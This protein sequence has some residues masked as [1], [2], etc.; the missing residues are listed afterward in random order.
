MKYHGKAWKALAALIFVAAGGIAGFAASAEAAELLAFVSARCAYCVAWEREVGRVYARTWEGR[1][2]PLRRV[3]ADAEN[4]ADLD[5]FADVRA[6][7]TFILVDGGRE[8]GRIAG[9]SGS[10]AFWPELDKLLARLR[11]TPSLKGADAIP[12]PSASEHLRRR[13]T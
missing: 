8:V 3:N 13:H 5:Q 11:S 4:G 10:D 9:Y 6:T 2:A 12:N 7:P 1:Q